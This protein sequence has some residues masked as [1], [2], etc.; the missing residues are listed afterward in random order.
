[1]I[2]LKTLVPG[3]FLHTSVSTHYTVPANT[4]AVITNATIA[5]SASSNAHTVT[6]YVVDAGASEALKDVVISSRTLAPL[7]TYKCP[8]LIGKPLSATGTLR[9]LC[10]STSTL[11]FNVGGYE[12]T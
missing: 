11:S 6:L 12:V 2:T 9:V 4:K 10:S 3:H 7:E 5:N 1:M 8:E